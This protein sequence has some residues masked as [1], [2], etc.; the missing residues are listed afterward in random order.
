[1]YFLVHFTM[2]GPLQ[3]SNNV[4]F[5]SPTSGILI[6]KPL[7]C[8]F[9]I[10]KINL[11]ILINIAFFMKKIQESNINSIEFGDLSY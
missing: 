2:F 9:L 7:E 3:T 1:M 10:N 6:S 4:L 11:I 8:N 5:F